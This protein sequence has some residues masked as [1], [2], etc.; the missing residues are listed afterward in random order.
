MFRFRTTAAAIMCCAMRP[1]RD[2]VA[3]DGVPLTRVFDTNLVVPGT[4]AAWAD[5]VHFRASDGSDPRTNGR[6]YTI[7]VTPPVVHFENLTLD[8]ILTRDI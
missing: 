3:E 5:V 2:G 8:E 7:L 6:Q 4:Y 1:V